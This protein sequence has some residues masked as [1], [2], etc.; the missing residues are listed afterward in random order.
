[1]SVDRASALEALLEEARVLGLLG[2]DP[3]ERHIR[4]G[5]ALAGRVEEPESF[6]D[7]G[8]GAG[9]PGLVLASVWPT[10]RGALLE[11]SARRS[12]FCSRAIELLDL[13]DRIR[14]VRARAE[15]AGRK[16]ELREHFDLVVARSFAR[17]AVTAEC[18][19]PFLQIGGTLLVSEPPPALAT[20]GRWP[21]ERLSELALGPGASATADEVSTM[22]VEKVGPTPER[23]PRRTGIPA[24]RPLW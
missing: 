17:P 12:A 13:S 5:R 20:A 23:F 16:P 15:V 18:A 8:S 6:L 19:A 4:H 7:L 2:P 21:R 3:V 10:A 22:V 11:A 9:V 24:K 1:M 14:V